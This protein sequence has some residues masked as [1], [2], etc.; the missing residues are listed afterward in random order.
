MAIR[1]LPPD[2]SRPET[3]GGPV[4]GS[5][6][7]RVRNLREGLRRSE[8]KVAQFVLDRP[9]QVVN[10]S[11]AD[12]AA[13]TGVSEPTIIRFCRA[14]ECRGFQDFKLRLAGSLAQTMPFVYGGIE[15]DDSVAEVCNKVFDRSIASL[16][17]ERNHLDV[18]LVAQA[19]DLLD[20]AS[21]IDFY[22]HGASG[23]VALDAQHKFFRLGTPAIAYTDPHLHSM[24]AATLK[25][26]CVVVAIS[27]SGRTVDLLCSIDIAREAGAS[28]IAITACGS[29]L[30]QRADIT[31]FSDAVEDSD[32]YTP[33]MS[34]IVHLVMI[35]A[36][37]VTLARKRGPAL[38]R[39][40][41]RTRRQWPQRKYLAE[42]LQDQS[43]PTSGRD[44]SVP[45]E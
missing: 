38:T 7:Q 39:L 45:G 1:A 16:I 24:S 40:L 8:Q 43:S 37:A 2:E 28:I 10:L 11:I 5:L 30:A 3:A 22:G 42:R 27:H 15:V 25:P 31:L 20:N 34:R 17:E 21:R 44:Y 35:D 14:V 29:P 6:L 13:R 4:Q 32:L 9:S 18:D 12:L 36:L 41:E 19:V 33:M 23:F 26:G